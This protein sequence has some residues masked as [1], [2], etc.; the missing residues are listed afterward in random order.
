M[1]KDTGGPAFPGESVVRNGMHSTVRVNN[2]G[3]TLRDYAMVH[4]VAATFGTAK[5]L[6]S[7]PEDER[8]QMWQNVVGLMS[9]AVDV[10][11]AERNK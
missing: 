11:L 10:M 6:G 8:K 1:T 5:N 2:S 9:E 4:M 3:M 7:I